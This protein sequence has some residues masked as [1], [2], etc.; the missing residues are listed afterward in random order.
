VKISQRGKLKQKKLIKTLRE[1]LL[2]ILK[3]M[4][5]PKTERCGRC[6]DRKLQPSQ[7]LMFSSRC[8]I[9]PIKALTKHEA[10]ILMVKEQVDIAQKIE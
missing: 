9:F 1:A 2:Q 6:F 3:S 8:N 10:F 5:L 4:R 7:R